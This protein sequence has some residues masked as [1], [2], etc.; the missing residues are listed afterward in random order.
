MLASCTTSFKRIGL[1]F[2]NLS[3]SHFCL[4]GG[5]VKNRGNNQ[6]AHDVYSFGRRMESVLA[7]REPDTGASILEEEVDK[8]RS[9]KVII[10][11]ILYF[12]LEYY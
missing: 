2:T 8:L 11:Y 12:S 3:W 6:A 5:G 10:V 7:S 1:S 9:E 4:F